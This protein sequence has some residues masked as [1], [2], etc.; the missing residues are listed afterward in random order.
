MAKLNKL[1]KFWKNKKVFIT[2]HTG[3]KGSWLIII[4]NF[5]GAKIY[6]YSL[7]PK[8]NSLFREIEGE[9]LLVKN[10]YGNINNKNFLKAK[11][12]SVKPHIVFHLAAQPLVIESYRNP[13]NTFKTNII[14]TANLL[15]SIKNTNFIKSI[16]IV[17]TDKVYKNKKKNTFFSEEDEL[18]GIDPYSTS[19]ACAEFITSS[20]IS[21]FF[22]NT[23]LK[24][25]ISSARSGNVIGGGDYSANRLVPDII[26]S[27]NNHKKLIIRNPKHVRP[28]LHVIEP[29]FGYMA[30]A[31]KQILKNMLH[32]PKW[33]FGPNKNDIIS[34]SKMIEIFKKIKP[35]KVEY[36]KTNIKIFESAWLK[37]SNNKSKKN[38]GWKPKWS[39]QESIDKVIEWNDLKM[40]NIH[41]KKICEYQIKNYLK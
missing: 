18:G 8:K 32:T 41:P 33:N 17:T 3:F 15:E 37:L 1:R 28:W 21:S 10:F 35:I 39:I 13:I 31:E 5:L 26:K 27:I 12:Y 6:G 24:N 2:G 16:V 34:V 19:K 7:K 9:K 20:Y 38:L 4:L 30:I 11:I 22:K 40:Q 36:L 29:L 14:G 23:N 25:K